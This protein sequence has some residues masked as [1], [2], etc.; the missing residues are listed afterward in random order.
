MLALE[1]AKCDFR[2]FG[3]VEDGIR[4]A[5]GDF[6]KQIMTTSKTQNKKASAKPDDG[7]SSVQVRID[8]EVLK[9]ARECSKEMELDCNMI[10]ETGVARGVM[11]AEEEVRVNRVHNLP[12]PSPFPDLNPGTLLE[13]EAFCEKRG[14]TMTYLM[15][16]ALIHELEKAK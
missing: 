13:A 14:W 7:K 8:R 11:T 10:F 2:I 15:N 6:T 9:R 3:D 12:S 1:G 4:L 5:F 16:R